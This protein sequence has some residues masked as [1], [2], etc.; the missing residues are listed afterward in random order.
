VILAYVASSWLLPPSGVNATQMLQNSLRAFAVLAAAGF[1]GLPISYWLSRF[2]QRDLGTLNIALS[3][4]QDP[5]TSN[6]DS[7]TSSRGG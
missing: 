2:I 6:E 3:S 1:V 4:P 7:L 5:W